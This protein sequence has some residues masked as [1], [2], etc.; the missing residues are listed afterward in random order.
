[1][2]RQSILLISL[3]W[4]GH[5]AINPDSVFGQQPDQSGWQ[6]TVEC[7]STVVYS[8]MY[9]QSRVVGYL[10]KGDQVKIDLEIIGSSGSWSSVT[11]PGKRVRL[12]YV[13][14]GCLK[15]KQQEPVIRWEAQSI[16]PAEMRP[17]PE[18]ALAADIAGQKAPT[19]EEIELEIDRRVAARLNALSSPTGIPQ[20]ES[21]EPLWLGD[22]ASFTFLPGFGGV[23]LSFFPRRFPHRITPF[24]TNP[25]PFS[26]SLVPPFIPSVQIHPGRMLRRK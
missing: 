14:S 11:S 13:Q 2:M 17:R 8:Q 4:L 12:G 21:P 16:P 19:R 3:L 5:N 23:P 6:A 20:T 9:T 7:D 25:A 24:P 26:R 15:R 10:K 18:P 22:R 1:M